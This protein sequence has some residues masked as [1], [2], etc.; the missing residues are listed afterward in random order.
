MSSPTK[1]CPDHILQLF[2]HE[3]TKAEGRRQ[4]IEWLN[5][6]Q[7]LPGDK[8]LIPDAETGELIEH[9]KQPTKLDS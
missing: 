5:W 8:V 7:L 2:K 4:V 1:V 6:Q 9:T 3:A